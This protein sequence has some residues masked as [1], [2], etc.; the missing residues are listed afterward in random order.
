MFYTE[1]TQHKIVAI[2]SWK[3]GR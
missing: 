3:Y 2:W 1:S